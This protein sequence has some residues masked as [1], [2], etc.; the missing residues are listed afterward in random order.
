MSCGVSYKWQHPRVSDES[1][2]GPRDRDLHKLIDAGSELAGGAASSAVGFL[3]GGA[4][5][6]PPGA[7]VGGALGSAAALALRRAGQEV[8][9]RVLAPREQVRSGAVLAIAAADIRARVTAGEALR[10][11]GFFDPGR[12]RRSAAEEVAEGVLLKA[13]REPEERKIRFMGNLLSSVAFDHEV[14]AELA[15]QLVKLAEQLTYRQLCILRVSATTASYGLHQA[16]FRGQRTFSKDLL[17]VLYECFDLYQRGLI[18]NGDA[19]ALGVSDINPSAM[20]TQGLGAELHNAMRLWE[21]P[22]EEVAA[23]AAVLK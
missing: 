12:Q 1:A 5:A 11:D 17:Q 9:E 16:A 14:N 8:S 15:H 3:V 2:E 4:V 6:G 10:S 20:K 19:V 7:I 21:I 13:Q 22:E 23:I 18:S